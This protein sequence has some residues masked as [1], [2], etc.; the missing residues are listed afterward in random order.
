VGV[1]VA[2]HLQPL[3]GALGYGLAA[4]AR[5]PLP[6]CVGIRISDVSVDT[7]RFAV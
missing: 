2:M 6:Y 3:A 7:G 4:L 1:T 5:L